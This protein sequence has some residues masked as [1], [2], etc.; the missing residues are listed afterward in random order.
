MAAAAYR[1][2][3]KAQRTVFAG[4]AKAR[5]AGLAETRAAFLQNAGAAADA[6]PALLK[7]ADDA[8]GFLRENIAQTVMNE[9]GNYELTPNE[10]F[11]HTGTTPPQIP[12][13]GDGNLNVPGGGGG[14]R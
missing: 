5:L 6:V 11:L 14:R 8:A 7:E 9:R 10:R 3:L 1:N 2:L 12:G 4:D 13:C